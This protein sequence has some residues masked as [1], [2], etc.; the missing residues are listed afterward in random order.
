MIAITGMHRSGTSCIAGLLTKCGYSLGTS[1]PLLNDNEGQFDNE[2][3]HFENLGPV[4]INE[5]ILELAGGTWY[6]PPVSQE[7]TLAG[8]KL[9]PH[10]KSFSETFNGHI[11]KDPRLCLTASIWERYCRNLFTIIFCLRSPLGVAI[12]LKKRNGIPL[13]AGLRLWYEY[14]I[15]FL[16]ETSQTPIIVVDYDNLATHFEF[17]LTTLLDELDSPLTAGEILDQVEGFYNPDLNHDPT[18]RTHIKKLPKGIRRVY[19]I[20]LSKTFSYQERYSVV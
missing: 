17:E 20:L 15:R 16:N 12:S 10:I 5:K 7:I 6:N 1:H 9:A 11:F 18:E 4:F 3:G 2:K 19:E 8:I 14:N 13:E